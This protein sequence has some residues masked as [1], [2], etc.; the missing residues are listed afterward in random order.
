MSRFGVRDI[1]EHN[2]S[3]RQ[4]ERNLLFVP[5]R[6]TVSTPIG[7]G[8]RSSIEKDYN[9]RSEKFDD[10]LRTIDELRDRI[11]DLPEKVSSLA[12]LFQYVPKIPVLNG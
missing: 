8:L 11:V 12:Y 4:Y 7:S 9:Q 2:I 10:D 6:R 3:F 1:C 5:P